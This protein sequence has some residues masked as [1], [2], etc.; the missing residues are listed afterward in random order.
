MAR[1]WLAM[2]RG[3]VLRARAIS[4]IDEPRTSAFPTSC[5]ALVSE[6]GSSGS[7][8]T[9][10]ER[11][12]YSS[13]PSVKR[14]ARSPKGGPSTTVARRDRFMIKPYERRNHRGDGHFESIDVANRQRSVDDSPSFFVPLVSAREIDA[15]ESRR[16]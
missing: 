7:S 16:S 12:R 15:S 14:L 13:A 1:T 3:D 4:R 6:V 8:S 5:S 9:G 2:V 11:T 10:Y